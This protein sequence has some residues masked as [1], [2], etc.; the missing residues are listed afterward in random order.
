VQHGESL[1]T[2]I[3]AAS[4]NMN[5]LVIAGATHSVNKI[6]DGKD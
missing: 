2:P 1:G 6:R 5:L 4:L 3:P